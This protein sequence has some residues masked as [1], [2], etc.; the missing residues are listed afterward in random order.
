MKLPIAKD[1]LRMLPR[2]G[3][4]KDSPFE[5]RRLKF[6]AGFTLIEMMVVLAILGLVVAMG[7]PS[8]IKALQKNGMRQAVGDVQDACLAAREKA[9]WSQQKVPVV[10][11]PQARTFGAEGAATSA[12]LPD[13]IEFAMLDIFRQDYA[14]SEWAKVFFNPDGTCDEAVIVLVGRGERE[15]ITLE[16]ATGRPVVSDVDK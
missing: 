8:L 11:Y 16:Y 1:E 12:K 15:K 10:F 13:G 5:I 2:V 7:A 14:E 4:G 6:A 3:N 9:I